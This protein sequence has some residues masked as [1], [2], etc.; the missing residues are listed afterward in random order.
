MGMIS[1]TIIIFT[2]DDSR[3]LRMK[4]KMTLFKPG[5]KNFLH[6]QGFPFC[7]AVHHSIISITAKW[8]LWIV[9][10]HPSVK[11]IVKEKV[12]KQGT[13]DSSLR[14]S[15]RPLSHCPILPLKWGF[16]PSLDVQKHPFAVCVFSHRPHQDSEA[17]AM[18]EDFIE[19]KRER[20]SLSLPY[21]NHLIILSIREGE[22]KDWRSAYAGG[23][24]RW[25]EERGQSQ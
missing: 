12:S 1:P 19:G 24:C 2:I 13:N 25:G 4:L 15:L 3:L 9:P 7:P 5:L 8:N 22:I 20:Q 14:C 11:H 10:F 17:K 6:Y 23:I 21:K 18:V 16:Q